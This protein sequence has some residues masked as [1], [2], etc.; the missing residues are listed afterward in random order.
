MMQILYGTTVIQPRNS[1][2]KNHQK[3]FTVFTVGMPG[4]SLRVSQL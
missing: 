4:N 2:E 1:W 3:L